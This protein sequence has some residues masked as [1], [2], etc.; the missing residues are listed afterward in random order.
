MKKVIYSLLFF[1]FAYSNLYSQYTSIKVNGLELGQAYTDS[2]IR[3]SLGTP[4]SVRPPSAGDDV[5][6]VTTYFYNNNVFFFQN[7]VL[8]DFV[9]ISSQFKLNN[10]LTVGMDFSNTAQMGGILSRIAS[11]VYY[12]YPNEIYR[13]NYEYAMINVNSSDNTI[14]SIVVESSLLKL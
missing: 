7:G 10:F 9:I 8:A 6:D 14:S 1:L 12:W 2:Q 4:T 5:Y 3:D 11:G 13:S